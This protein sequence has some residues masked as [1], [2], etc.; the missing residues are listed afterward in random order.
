MGLFNPLINDIC[1]CGDQFQFTCAKQNDIVLY[2]DNPNCDQCFCTLLTDIIKTEEQEKLLVF[3]NPFS[4]Q[5]TLR[6]DNSFNDATLTV[7]NLYGQQ[8]KQIKNISGKSITFYR[9]NL[10][11]GLYFLRLTRENKTLATDKLV[12]IDD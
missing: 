8:V 12:I 9:D 3:P 4:N 7:Y 11:C 1:T 6:I 5:T 10:S 2:L